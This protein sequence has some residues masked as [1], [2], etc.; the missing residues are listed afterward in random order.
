MRLTLHRKYEQEGKQTKGYS[1]VYDNDDKYIF[2]CK[3]LEPPWRENQRR[4]SCIPEGDY[5]CVKRTSPKYGHHWHVQDVPNR[6]LILIHSGN[7]NTHTL[8]CILVGREFADINGDG[9][10]DVTHSKQMMD[11]LRKI[12]DDEF[13]LSIRRFKNFDEKS[14]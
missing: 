8:G 9:L 6:D 4:I 12:L 14:T 3:T 1:H 2:S 11:E 13:F 5:K 10:C 7:F